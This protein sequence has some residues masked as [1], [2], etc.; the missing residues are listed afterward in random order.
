MFDSYV[1]EQRRPLVFDIHRYALDDGPGIRTTVFF[2][3]C[4][5]ACLWCHN[6]EGTSDGPELFH[7][8]QTCI[9]CGDCAEACPHQ[10]VRLTPAVT[11]DRSRCN[12]CG[13]CVEACPSGA[14]TLKGRYYA[15][16][17][18]VETICEDKVF[19][20]TSGGGATFSGGEPTRYMSYLAQ[21][22]TLLKT[23]QVHVALQT[24][25]QFDWKTFQSTILP[26]TDLIYF[27]IKCVDADRHRR[28]TGHG[29]G[30]IQANFHRL[31]NT[32]PHKMVCTIPL[33]PGF[34]DDQE[35]LDAVVRLI[36]AFPGLDYR[37]H[38]YHPGPYAKSPA[39]GKTLHEDLPAV[40]MPPDRVERIAAFFNT[41]GSEKEGNHEPDH[42]RNHIQ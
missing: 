9:A 39:L 28:L 40:G 38:P 19:F 22:L 7:H 23:R 5:L 20:D 13:A 27:D 33:V 2:K 17:Q 10:A 18:L 41:L 4:P 8:S 12:A 24:C 15:A 16:G 26:L 32:A 1:P 3:G 25:G 31:M 21:V 30:L 37:L 34:N 35:N 29:N 36:G 42:S 11:I 6:P 14:M